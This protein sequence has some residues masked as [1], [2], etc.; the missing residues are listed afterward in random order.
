MT[1][2]RLRTILCLIQKGD[3]GTTGI[4]AAKGEPG[5]SISAPIVVVSPT[6][7]TINEGGTA[8]FQCS[9]TGNPE[10]TVVWS[11]SDLKQSADS[12]GELIL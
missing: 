12:G 7:L 3:T 11:K 1:F 6:K 8:S 4:P 9:V 5:E 10:P 2:Y